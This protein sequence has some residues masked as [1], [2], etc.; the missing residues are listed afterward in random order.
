MLQTARTPGLN[1][2]TSSEVEEVTGFVGN[3]EV[4]IRKRA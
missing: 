3:F 2:H 1:L 4:K